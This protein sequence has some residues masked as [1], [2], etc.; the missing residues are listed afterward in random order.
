MK[1]YYDAYIAY[2]SKN[3]GFEPDRGVEMSVKLEDI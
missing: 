3:I 1:N 2:L